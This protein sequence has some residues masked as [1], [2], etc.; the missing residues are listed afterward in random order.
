VIVRGLAFASVAC[1][2]AAIALTVFG[3]ADAPV[4]VILILVS[5]GISTLLG[6]RAA[7]HKARGFVNDARTFIT[8]DIQQARLVAVGDPKGILN[9]ESEVT[10][11]LEG[12]DGA[13]HTFSRGVPVPFPLAWSYRLGKRFN[14]P[15]LRSY[16]NSL[17]AFELRREGMD[18]DVGRSLA[19]EAGT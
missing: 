10:V 18:V 12:D 1:L 14:L 15:W 16:L 4:I 8:G 11:E 2:L 9:P 7:F 3:G 13:V 6:I 5:F 19:P 17:M